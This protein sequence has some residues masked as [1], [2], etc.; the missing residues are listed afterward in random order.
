MLRVGLKAWLA[1]ERTEHAPASYQHICT[2]NDDVRDRHL[3][4][5]DGILTRSTGHPFGR[6]L[7]TRVGHGV[8]TD[9][10][11]EGL[12]LRRHASS[13]HHFWTARSSVCPVRMNHTSARTTTVKIFKTMAASLF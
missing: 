8:I 1:H 2:T 6:V 7:K 10:F 12:S 13:P 3:T 5:C 11:V 9:D 4:S